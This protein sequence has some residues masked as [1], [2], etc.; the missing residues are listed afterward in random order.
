VSIQRP[1]SFRNYSHITAVVI[2]P[3]ALGILVSFVTDDVIGNMKT[4]EA[5]RH[6]ISPHLTPR[7]RTTTLPH[8]YST[9]PL[10]YRATALASLRVSLYRA[11]TRRR[12]R[13]MR[14][15]LVSRVLR[16][17]FPFGFGLL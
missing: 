7:Y 14:L 17:L 9:A 15:R 12:K 13:P 5:G 8:G 16:A 3:S 2:E 6:D 1:V 10:L 11:F 4:A